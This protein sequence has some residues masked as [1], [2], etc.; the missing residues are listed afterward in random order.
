MGYAPF[1]EAV[2]L[3]IPPENI[4]LSVHPPRKR[5]TPDAC[6]WEGLP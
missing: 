3:R 5:Q 1:G 4:T 2:V 6:S